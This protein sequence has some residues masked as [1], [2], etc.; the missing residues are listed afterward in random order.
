[1]KSTQPS[2]LLPPP[3]PRRAELSKDKE[4]KEV[5]VSSVSPSKLASQIY[6]VSPSSQS[7]PK[8]TTPKLSLVPPF[9]QP[10]VPTRKA[11]TPRPKV[12]PKQTP[13]IAAISSPSPKTVE[14]NEIQY[15]KGQEVRLAT[16]VKKGCTSPR[17]NVNSPVKMLNP[18]LR[19]KSTTPKKESQRPESSPEVYTTPPSSAVSKSFL[20][21]REGSSG[22]FFDDRKAMSVSGDLFGDAYKSPLGGE[23]SFLDGGNT[24]KSRVSSVTGFFSTDPGD[25]KFGSFFDEDGSEDNGSFSLGFGGGND[26]EGSGNGGFSLF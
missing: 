18:L 21:N 12:T 26:D 9:P 1:V 22:G 13:L 16:P 10:T 19:M 11:D 5:E 24:Q 8:L 2:V 7:T 6:F 25:G 4:E 23:E 3:K 17:K 20:G 15:N 14:R